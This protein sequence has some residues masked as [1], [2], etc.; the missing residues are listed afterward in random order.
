MDPMEL[1]GQKPTGKGSERDRVRLKRKTLEVVLQQCQVALQELTDVLDDDDADGDP[2]ALPDFDDSSS[3]PCCDAETAE[4][5]DLLQSMVEGTDFLEKLENARAALP[6]NMSEEGNSWDMVSENE[7]WEVRNMESDGEDFVFVRQEDIVEGIACFMAAYLLSLKQAK[8]VTPNQ[9]QEAL[10]KTFSVK[11]NKGKLQKAWD[12]SRAIY[13]V[14][15]WGATAIGIYQNPA[16]LRAA[17][18]AFWTSCRA[19]SKLL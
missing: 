1:T 10:R 4:F 14:A 6:Q 8:D 7:V 12:G 16:L 15:S 5:C 13:N 18:A 11:K 3:S 9:L 2:D 17:G 19:I